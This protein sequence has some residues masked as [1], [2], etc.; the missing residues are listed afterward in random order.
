MRGGR[1]LASKSF[2]VHERLPGTEYLREIAARNPGDDFILC[3]C[4]MLT[5]NRRLLM[6]RAEIGGIRGGGHRNSMGR[7][8]RRQIFVRPMAKIDS[9]Q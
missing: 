6:G 3:L 1:P 7:P 5:G 8:E 2:R 9:Y 4:L